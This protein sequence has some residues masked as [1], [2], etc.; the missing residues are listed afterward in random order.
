MVAFTVDHLDL[1][2]S[3][4]SSLVSRAPDVRNLNWVQ[5][6]VGAKLLSKM[7]WKQGQAVGRRSRVNVSEEIPDAATTTTSG[8][9]EES[10]QHHES[11]SSEGL[12]VVKRQDGLGLGASHI[13]HTET[14]HTKDFAQLLEHLN[15]QQSSLSTTKNNSSSSKRK[16]DK[17]LHLPTNKSTHHKVRQAKFRTKTTD[18]M[19][20]IFA[21]AVDYSVFAAATTESTVDGSSQTKKSSKKSSKK[22]KDR[23]SNKAKKS[24]DSDV[25]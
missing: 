17:T 20:C 1:I 25:I 5:D 19:K 10:E 21:G 13:L 23:S 22:S 14:T 11:I 15:Q 2:M 4:Q 12:R 16:R 24:I 3:S 9:S 18:D 6:N 8:I 7:G